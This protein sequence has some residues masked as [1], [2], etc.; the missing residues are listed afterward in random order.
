MRTSRTMP[1]KL[2][3]APTPLSRE[4]F[5]VSRERSKSSRCTETFISAS[6]HRRE[7]R[8]LVAGADRRGGLGHVLVDGGA[9]VLLLRERPF[10]R[11]AALREVAAQGGDRRHT[12]RQ[13][14]LLGRGAELL[15][16]RSEEEN[17]H[18][19]Q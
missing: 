14:K 11:A 8:D 5:F 1:T 7:E 12:R 4:R 16:Q 13:L 2:A 10:P 18:F 17:F 9:H 15:A 19:H 3:T 6:G